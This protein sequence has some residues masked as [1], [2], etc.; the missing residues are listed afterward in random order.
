M[1]SFFAVFPKHITGLSQSVILDFCC[2][3]KR[4]HGLLPVFAPMHKMEDTALC[5]AFA[6][7]LP[8]SRAVNVCDAASLCAMLR[9]SEFSLCMRLHAAVFSVATR[10][11]VIAVSDDAKLASFVSA[12]N[13]CAFFGSDATARELCRAA[14]TALSLRTENEKLLGRYAEEQ[15]MLARAEL[16]RLCRCFWGR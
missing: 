3:M 1:M 11:P 6:A 15:K 4:K 10:R 16:E 14:S 5:R 2:E 9:A 12:G 8:F 7:R 13:G